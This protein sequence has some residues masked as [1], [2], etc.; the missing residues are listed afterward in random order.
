MK[1]KVYILGVAVASL[2]GVGALATPTNAQTSSHNIP[3]SLRGTWYSHSDKITFTT[4]SYFEDGHKCLSS[5]WLGLKKINVHY[6]PGGGY[7]LN[8]GK[9]DYDTVG[10]YE[11]IY[12]N[13]RKALR[14]THMA[15][16]AV[17]IYYY[18]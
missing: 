11:V 17:T 12:H 8:N 3:R 15:S 6:W 14:Y 9:Y 7:D 4:H 1:F 18:R 13:G 2:L 5:Y 10:T 16:P